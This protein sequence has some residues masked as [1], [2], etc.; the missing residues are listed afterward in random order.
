MS[1]VTIVAIVLVGAACASEGPFEPVDETRAEEIRA[2]LED[3]SFRQFDPHMDGSPRKG[4]ILD[5]FGGLSLWAQY[6]EGNHAIH[7]WE[8]SSAEY[9]IEQSASGA[10]I[11]L[12][13]IAPTSRRTLT[14]PCDDC[15]PV[16]GI[17]IWIRDAFDKDRISFRVNDPDGALP[18]PFP[19]FTSWTRFQ[20]DEH[21][22]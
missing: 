12:H 6:A 19:V 5:F 14:T 17:S 22:D 16:A 21:F 11:R 8:I 18:S 10:E 13:F 9:R 1:R 4:V 3:R 2:A 20:E 7:E 15:I